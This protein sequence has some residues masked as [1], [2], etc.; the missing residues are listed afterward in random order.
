[1]ASAAGT[2]EL[3]GCAFV[4][5]SKSSVSSECAHIAFASA[6]LTA[7]VRN[8]LPMTEACTSP[9]S[10]RAYFSP[11]MPGVMREPDTIAPNVSRIRCLHSSS[12]AG[13]NSWSRADT[14]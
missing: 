12:T 3:P 9:P 8:L 11:I 13:G 6:A 4:T 10:P 5:G 14:M 7:V 2:T 1:M